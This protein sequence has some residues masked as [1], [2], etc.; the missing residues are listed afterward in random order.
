MTKEYY[1]EIEDG[2]KPMFIIRHK[3]LMISISFKE[4]HAK[5]ICDALN[6]YMEHAKQTEA[7]KVS[8]F[9]DDC[10]SGTE[11]FKEGD[12]VTIRVEQPTPVQIAEAEL[13]EGMHT[14]DYT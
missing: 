6:F 10:I 12:T 1:Y 8:C 7:E 14:G 9:S 2:D 11:D 3:L 4:D 5:L 13:I